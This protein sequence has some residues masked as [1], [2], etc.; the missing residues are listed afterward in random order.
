MSNEKEVVSHTVLPFHPFLRNPSRKRVSFSVRLVACWRPCNSQPL[1][2]SEAGQ[3]KSP[4]N[5][6]PGSRGKLFL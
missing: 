5:V 3:S 1:N 2:Y 6:P 4:Q